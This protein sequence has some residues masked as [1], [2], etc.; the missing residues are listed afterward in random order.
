MSKFFK[1]NVSAII[2]NSEGKI[3]IQ[4]RSLDEDVFPGLWGIPGGTVEI[5]DKSV[6][7]ALRREIREEV[8]VEIDDAVLYK[9]NLV[10]KEMYGVYYLVYVSTYISGEARALDGTSE[11]LWIEENQIDNYEFT[12]TT[13]KTIFKYFLWK[14]SQ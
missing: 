10:A 14:K 3:L 6:L 1:I 12:P 9:E 2:S 4:K 11:V 5:S 7:D 13:K 8:G